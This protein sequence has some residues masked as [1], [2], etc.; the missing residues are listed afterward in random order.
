[1]TR[2]SP[3]KSAFANPPSSANNSPTPY[4]DLLVR[5]LSGDMNIY[6]PKNL[7]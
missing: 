1:V 2:V 3:I 4:Y 6:I 5:T 7:Y